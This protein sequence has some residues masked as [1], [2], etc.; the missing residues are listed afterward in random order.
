[1]KSDGEQVKKNRIV[2]ANQVGDKLKE[3]GSGAT[4]NLRLLCWEEIEW[5]LGNGNIVLEGLRIVGI[6]TMIKQIPEV[7]GC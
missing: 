3:L 5:V 6:E 7:E 1:M 4:R 2:S